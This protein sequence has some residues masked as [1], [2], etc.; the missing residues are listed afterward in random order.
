MEDLGH[1]TVDMERT[2]VSSVRIRLAQSE[3][4]PCSGRV[5]ILLNSTWGTVCDDDWDL[6]DAEVVCR[7]LGCGKAL[8]A[9]TSA[10][11]G[12]G[13]GQIWMDDVKCSGRESSL[14]Q[15]QHGGFGTHNCGHGED[16]GV[17]CTVTVMNHLEDSEDDEKK[18]K[19]LYVN[20]EPA[21]STKKWGQQTR[22]MEEQ[23]SDDNHDYEEEENNGSVYVEN[24]KMYV[25]VEDNGKE[26]LNEQNVAKE[27]AKEEES[28]D[29]DDDYVNVQ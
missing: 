22:A 3:S 9:T 21:H 5:E 28:S 7:E 6:N 27:V 25:T 18:E 8:N 16:A 14:S 17:I 24:N 12:Q 29:T 1:T 26:E 15:C 10:H 2:L 23:E 20:Y 13:T 19:Q 4:A 11:F